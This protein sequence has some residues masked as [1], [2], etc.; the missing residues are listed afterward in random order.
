VKKFL[1]PLLLFVVL[2]VILYFGLSQDPRAIPSPLIDKPLPHFSLTTLSDPSR[3]IDSAD[4]RGR[5]YLINVW[6]SWC[7]ACRDEH[8]LLTEMANQKIVPI[9]G[10]NYKD[11]REDALK[12]LA[13]M[14]DPYE[15]SVADRDGR[16]GIELGVYGVPETF[17]IDRDGV[18]RY[19]HIGPLTAEALQKTLLVKINEL[20]ASNTTQVNG[21]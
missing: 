8:P 5:V 19:K 20:R 18:I 11:K 10:L 16:V 3:R 13:E 15:L 9:I 6:A 1:V 7:V 17:L 21:K 12:W 14:G 4:W 2:G